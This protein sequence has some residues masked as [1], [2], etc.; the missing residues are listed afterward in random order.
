MIKDFG[1]T[2]L[3][4]I[5]FNSDEEIGLDF[6]SV[7]SMDIRDIK[8]IS[9]IRAAAVLNGKK[10]YAKNIK[11]DISGVLVSTGLHKMFENF[12]EFTVETVKRLV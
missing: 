8:K 6:S 11:T 12:E 9:D 10:L 3:S 7:G 1:K 5:D 4:D 2:E